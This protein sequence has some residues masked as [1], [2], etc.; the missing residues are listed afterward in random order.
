MQMHL[1]QRP[2]RPLRGTLGERFDQ[3]KEISSDQQQAREG[4]DS[5]AQSPKAPNSVYM[6]PYKIPNTFSRAV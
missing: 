5:V 2:P 4:K 6:Y 1:V 3:T